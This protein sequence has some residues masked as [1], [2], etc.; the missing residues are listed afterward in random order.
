MRSAIAVLGLLASTGLA[1]AADL[2]GPYDTYDGS[3]KDEPILRPFSWT[4]L[5][6]GLN[7]GYG[8]ANISSFLP[9]DIDDQIHYVPPGGVKTDLEP[10]GWFGGGQIG[11]NYQRDSVVFGLEADWQGGDME[12]SSIRRYPHIAFDGNPDVDA[13]FDT[14]TKVKI[15]QFGT[16]RGRVGLALGK[17]LPYVTGG[18]AWAEAKSES[19]T[20]YDVTVPPIFRGPWVAKDSVYHIGWTVGGGVEVALTD[21]LSVKAEYLYLDFGDATHVTEYV[22]AVTGRLGDTYKTEPDLDMHSLRIGVNYKF[23]G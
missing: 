1:S 9:E 13:W 8:W 23:G 16:V 14:T 6:V 12:A 20:L 17:F 2:G 3:L 15:D 11:F 10:D 7:V 5:Y 4:G 21:N 22:N 19:T 18:L